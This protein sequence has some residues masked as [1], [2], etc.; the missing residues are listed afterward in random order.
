[1]D[2]DYIMQFYNDDEP[3]YEMML[4]G[5]QTIKD[6][7]KPKVVI[8]PEPTI[9]GMEDMPMP[10]MVER[11]V[12][13]VNSLHL[14]V[15]ANTNVSDIGMACMVDL[16]R[17]RSEFAGISKV[18]DLKLDETI[19]AN[20]DYSREQLIE[21]LNNLKPEPND[22]VVF[23][24]SG[25]GFRF[26]DQKDYYPNMDLSPTAYDEAKDNYLPLSQVFDSITAKGA[27]L[28]IVLSD[29]CNSEIDETLPII[30]T[31]S[32]F[33]RSNKN[34]DR[35]KMRSLF[36]QSEGNIIATAASP[37][38]VSWCGSNGGFFLLSL[39]ESLRNQIS[40]LSDDDPSWESLVQN[41]IDAAALKSESN[42]NCK[43]QNGVKY[44]K[45]KS[46]G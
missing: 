39:I 43:K 15:T 25:H 42:K 38:E 36:L 5:I 30:S 7:A 3:E 8:M 34:F 18:L 9:E 17:V 32:L 13:M 40:A 21:A 2:E 26:K 1:M 14:V 29:C 4:K 45:V 10:T 27:R 20:N 44:V 19:V 11:E 41:A 16:N 35:Q 46:I 33:S 37:G 12:E 22:V 23:V 6:Q 28:N 31:N 24:Y